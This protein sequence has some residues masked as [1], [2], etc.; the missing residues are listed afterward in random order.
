MAYEF[1]RNKGSYKKGMTASLPIEVAV[2]LLKKGIIIEVKIEEIKPK[3]LP[4][5]SKNNQRD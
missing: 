1:L 5:R 4:N 3:K 2:P